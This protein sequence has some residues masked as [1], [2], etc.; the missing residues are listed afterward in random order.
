MTYLQALSN[1]RLLVRLLPP[2]NDP[3]PILTSLNA[4][5]KYSLKSNKESIQKLQYRLVCCKIVPEKFHSQQ[6]RNR[7]SIDINTKI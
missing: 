4:I 6:G 7:S 3:I 1:D 2:S 5:N